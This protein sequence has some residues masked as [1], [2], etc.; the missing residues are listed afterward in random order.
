[1]RPGLHVIVQMLLLAQDMKALGL[2]ANGYFCPTIRISAK[3]NQFYI[4]IRIKI[5][6]LNT[7]FK[8]HIHVFVPILF[9]HKSFYEV[10]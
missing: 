6:I 4:A 7:I 3:D 8:N 1:M 5:R 10:L 9:D 2:S